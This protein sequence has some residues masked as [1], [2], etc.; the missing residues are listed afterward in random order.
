MEKQ[1]SKRSP[2]H[3]EWNRP[4][5]H[6]IAMPSHARFA[7][8]PNATA[9]D[10]TGRCSHPSTLS[11]CLLPLRLAIRRALPS[12]RALL[13]AASRNYYGRIRYDRIRDRLRDQAPDHAAGQP[14]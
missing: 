12:R 9:A 7:A 2:P 6:A 11:S 1:S 10:P 13:A 14:E 4:D 8:R 5:L 3:S